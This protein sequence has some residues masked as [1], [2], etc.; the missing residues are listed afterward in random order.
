MQLQ[1]TGL[2]W[3]STL[4]VHV[5]CD[6]GQ[7]HGNAVAVRVCSVDQQTQHVAINTIA[8]IWRKVEDAAAVIWQPGHVV[9]YMWMMAGG[10]GG[11]E[12]VQGDAAP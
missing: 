4:L 1:Y 8:V 10:R 5:L 2:S 6:W 9:M 7:F 3:L 11:W 12:V